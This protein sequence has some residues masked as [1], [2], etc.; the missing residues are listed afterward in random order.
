MLKKVSE[1]LNSPEV[2]AIIAAKIEE[3]RKK[4]MEEVQSQLA[5]EKEALLEEERRK[6]VSP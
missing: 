4:L 3:G 2:K 1:A 5:S 6:E